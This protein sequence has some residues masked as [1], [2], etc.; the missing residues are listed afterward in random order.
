ML[1]HFSTFQVMRIPLARDHGSEAGRGRANRAKCTE[2]CQRRPFNAGTQV[3][4]NFLVAVLEGAGGTQRIHL[5]L[6]C[7][8]YFNI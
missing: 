7:P 1:C 8:E 4:L 6:M 3:I 2:R 5:N